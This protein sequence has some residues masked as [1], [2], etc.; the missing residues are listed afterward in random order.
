MLPQNETTPPVRSSEET[1][2]RIFAAT[3]Q[4]I[5][6]KGRRGTTTREIAELAGV[7]EATLFRHFGNKDALIE[8]CVLHYTP[9]NILEELLPSLTGDV[10]HDLRK[11]ARLMIDE[12]EK[13]RDLIMATFGEEE[14][15]AACGD[16]AWRG[17]SRIHEMLK[18]FMAR[19]VETGELEGDPALLARFFMGTLFSY[20]IGRKR[21]PYPLE[22]V[23]ELIDFNINV[24]L[25]GVRKKTN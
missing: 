13:L 15:W 20:V 3:R 2:N 18:Q 9:A 12:M 6:K 8:A 24:F 17:P 14:Q 5:A 1:R 19:R 11:I 23:D 25:N 10:A 7:N 4:L 21:L 22:S 16:A